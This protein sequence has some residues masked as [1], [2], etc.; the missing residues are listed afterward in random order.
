MVFYLIRHGKPDYVTDTLKPEGIE[1]ARLCARRMLISGADRIYSSPM[2]RARET[3]APLAEALG[4]GVTVCEWA[5]ELSGESKTTYPDGVPKAISNLPVTYLH[6]ES[7]RRLAVGE[8][9]L[10]VP[11]LNDSGFPE[12]YREISEGLDALLAENGYRRTPEGFYE[13]TG[14]SDR[15]VV[16]FAHAG[17]GRVIMSHLL[18]IPYN[19]FGSAIG[20]NYTGVTS[21]LFDNADAGTVTSPRLA[22]FGDIGHLYAGGMPPVYYLSKKSI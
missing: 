7:F 17:M 9:L 8:E 5:R 14:G 4:L 12:R 3:A 6:G 20:S 18:H 22:T 11:G 16:L 2:G 13:V 15:H 21:F 10:E 19:Y 1:Q